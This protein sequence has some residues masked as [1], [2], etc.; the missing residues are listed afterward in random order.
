MLLLVHTLTMTVADIEVSARFFH[1][2]CPTTRRRQQGFVTKRIGVAWS[3]NKNNF[4]CGR[5]KFRNG[6]PL[7]H[8][9]LQALVM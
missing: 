8:Q 2:M 3:R 5:P 7:F 6:P 1:V 4:F 9:N